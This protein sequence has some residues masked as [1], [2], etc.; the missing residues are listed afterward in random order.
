MVRGGLPAAARIALVSSSMICSPSSIPALEAGEEGGACS[1]IGSG[2][3]P[4]VGPFT[5]GGG[6]DSEVVSGVG[7]D[8]G[9][10][11]GAG[12]EDGLET[13]GGGEVLWVEVGGALPA[14]AEVS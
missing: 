2:V 1:G 7:S 3:D 14:G 8:V 11:T 9:P 13:G 4:D 6:G 10:A 12:G 5:G